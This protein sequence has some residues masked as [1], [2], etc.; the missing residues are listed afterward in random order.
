MD[1]PNSLG[2]TPS[3]D[4]AFATYLNGGLV[5]GTACA[6][7]RSQTRESVAPPVNIGASGPFATV[8]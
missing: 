7:A 4:S 2:G 8:N 1:M 3:V 5:T 6:T